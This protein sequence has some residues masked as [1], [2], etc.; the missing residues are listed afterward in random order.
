M[1]DLVQLNNNNPDD[2]GGGGKES[3]AVAAEPDERIR[4]VFICVVG[5]Y[6]LAIEV[7]FKLAK[8]FHRY[9]ISRDLTL[10]AALLDLATSVLALLALSPSFWLAVAFMA[11]VVELFRGNPDDL[12]Q[13]DRWLFHEPFHPV[14]G[15]IF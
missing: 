13:A 2:D 14:L 1:A 15:R 11:L 7:F 6:Y 5:F 8:D 12:L 3:E 4:L 10:C 9:A